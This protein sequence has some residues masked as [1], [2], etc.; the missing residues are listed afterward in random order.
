[1]TTLFLLRMHRSGRG[2]RNN[3]SYSSVHIHD[4]GWHA[5]AV[6]QASERVLLKEQQ[7]AKHA[8]VE[9][10]HEQRTM[11]AKHVAEEDASLEKAAAAV[12]A[13]AR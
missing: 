9:A 8:V 13:K 4:L 11:D 6:A 2:T 10:V 1:M 7:K 5:C 3:S 12:A